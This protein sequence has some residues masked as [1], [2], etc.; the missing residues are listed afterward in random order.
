VEWADQVI[1][2]AFDDCT[3]IG[4]CFKLMDS[5]EG[6]LDRDL[7]ATDLEKKHVDLMRAYGNEVPML[8]Q[9]RSLTPPHVL[10]LS[11]THTPTLSPLSHPH[12]LYYLSLLSLCSLF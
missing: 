6:L 12:V 2:Q 8:T 10:L 1:T 4:N 7:I 9:S 3:T 11:L 5:F